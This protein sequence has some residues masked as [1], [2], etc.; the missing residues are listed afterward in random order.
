MPPAVTPPPA[1]S[2][3]PA[4]ARTAVAAP[5][6][7]RRWY[8]DSGFRRVAIATVF[9]AVLIV[10]WHFIAMALPGRQ[11]LLFPDPLSVWQYLEHGFANG[12]IWQALWVTTRRLLVGYFSGLVVGIPLGIVTAR[13]RWASDTIGV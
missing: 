5:I 10:G 4:P 1:A 6:V 11:R 13:F 7:P 12:D 9:F 8:G 3:R 2:L